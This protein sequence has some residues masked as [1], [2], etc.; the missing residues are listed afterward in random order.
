MFDEFFVFHGEW[1]ESVEKVLSVSEQGALWKQ[2]CR[3]AFE[4]KEDDLGEGL[5]SYWILMR[6]SI[7]LDR[8]LMDYGEYDY[9]KNELLDGEELEGDI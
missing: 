2:C 7:D 6:L 3:Y 1:L 9:G 8:K 5:N 4:G